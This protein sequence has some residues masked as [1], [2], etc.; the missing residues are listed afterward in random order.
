MTSTKSLTIL[1]ADD[2]EDDS[3]ILKQFL[4]ESYPGIQL[5]VVENGAHVM[6]YLEKDDPLPDAIFLDLNMPIK[7]GIEC[8][9]EIKSDDR[10]K[11]IMTVIVTTSSDPKQK[12][13]C[14]AEGADL[15]I[16]KP[17]NYNHFKSAFMAALDKITS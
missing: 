1:V 7:N 3:D 12:N 5:I 11:S 10:F 17:S 4:S 13:N 8:L 9:R 2:D 15:F 16:T 14:Y 6:E